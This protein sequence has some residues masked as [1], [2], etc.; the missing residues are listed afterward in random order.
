MAD[1]K[2]LLQ[3]IFISTANATI[4][5]VYRSFTESQ[6]LIPIKQQQSV[7]GT[8][9]EPGAGTHGVWGG[10]ALLLMEGWLK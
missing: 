5:M 7:P 10:G 8:G 3:F 4:L 9:W 1:V 6:G 2:D